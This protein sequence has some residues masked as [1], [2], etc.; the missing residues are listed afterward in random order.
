MQDR[1]HWNC[2]A[3]DPNAPADDVVLAVGRV[4]DGASARSALV[5]IKFAPSGDTPPSLLR[6]IALGHYARRLVISR[7]HRCVLVGS[8]ESPSAIYTAP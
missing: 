4:A 1:Y 6:E 3:V 8:F 5:Q 7:R 2:V